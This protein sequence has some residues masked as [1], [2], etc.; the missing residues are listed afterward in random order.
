MGF[1]SLIIALLVEQVRPLHSHNVAYNAVRGT[2]EVLE[3]NFNA[4]EKQQG[5]LAWFI[6]VAPL[7]VF[8]WLIFFLLLR[9]HPF[10]ALAWNALVL[11][12]TL[13]FRQ[14]S[15]FYTDIQLAL[16]DNDLERAR[17]LLTEWKR[18]SD[19]TFSAS[20]LVL[21]DICRLAIEE[22]LVASHRHVFGVFFWFV[23]LPG[24]SGA[25]LYR[26]SDFLARRWNLSNLP[27]EP[28]G[29]FA[30]KAFQWIDWI[31]VRLTAVGFAIVGNFEDAV[32]CWRN[33][34]QQWADASRGILLAAGTGALGVRL[35]PAAR[36][37]SDVPAQPSGD[38]TAAGSDA[39][40]EAAAEAAVDGMPGVD[41]SPAALHSA[42]G[43]V[44][45]SMLL[46]TLLLL[47]LSVAGL[48]G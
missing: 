39:T 47:L 2:A 41:A 6:L 31:P 15:H 35:G 46:W 13:G 43:L 3:R 17:A 4:G 22:A 37:A 28:F 18:E 10:L 5:I 27:L 9:V 23:L 44:W 40:A 38:S 33:H 30:R 11:Y 14:F 7:T 12:L 25:V 26:L 16:A 20:D 8:A 34:V 32:F 45:R 1:L 42:V 29:L 36:N 48:F 19:P 24:P 21:S